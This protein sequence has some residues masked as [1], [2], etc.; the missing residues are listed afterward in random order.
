MPLPAGM[1]RS[2]LYHRPC[3]SLSCRLASYLQ[4]LQPG[5]Q[6]FRVE[7]NLRWRSHLQHY[8]TEDLGPLAGC[9]AQAL[10]YGQ[11]PPG[12]VLAVRQFSPLRRR[13]GCIPCR[14]PSIFFF[15]FFGSCGSRWATIVPRWANIAPRWANIAPRWAHIA[16]KIGQHSPKMGQHRPPTIKISCV[17][18][19][20]NFFAVPI[21]RLFRNMG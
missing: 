4:P 5:P 7:E 1:T 18:L 9:R 10:K 3:Q 12:R 6:E 17:L 16:F 20:Y 21:F 19:F 13:E 15:F 8:P 14:R 11:G 2:R